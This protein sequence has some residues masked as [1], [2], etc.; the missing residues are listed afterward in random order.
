MATAT[1]H[2]NPR[3][4]LALMLVDVNRSFFDT[5]G[6]FYYPGAPATLGPIRDLLEAAREGG[7][8]VVH[9]REAHR[10]GFRDFERPK[11]PEHNYVGDR[12]QE[13]YP[14]FEELPGEV[15]IP[16]RRFSAFFATDLALIFHEQAVERVIIA[17]VKTNV[18]IRASVQDAFAYGLRP[19]IARGSVSSNRPHLHEAS[20]ED[21]Q[22]YI[23]EVVD[24][25]TAVTWL[26]GEGPD[27]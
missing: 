20:L 27:G 15:V 23:G 11:L 5:D 19:T 17:G 10:R 3:H 13:A 1:P 22:R 6:P 24:L 21:I 4:R 8:L 7:R 14:G 16:K 9:A 26:R 18:C 2:P 25:E 12:D